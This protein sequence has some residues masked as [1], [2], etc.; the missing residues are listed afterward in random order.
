MPKSK[1]EVSW[2]AKA[3]DLMVRKDLNIFQAV[4]LLNLMM[5]REEADG[6][7]AT[8]SFQKIQRAARG[9]HFSE[10]AND[11]GHNKRSLIGKLLVAADALMLEGKQDKAAEVLH[12]IAK[13]E[14]WE[15]SGENIT[16]IG[17]LTQKDL[18]EIRQK[19][20]GN[21]LPNIQGAGRV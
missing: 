8:D 19:L 16:I 1:F 4:V 11:P 13:I 20:S 18:D 14:G 15:K 7:F 3:A 5:T 17:D 10:V 9:R 12:K 2:Y 6:H 21:N